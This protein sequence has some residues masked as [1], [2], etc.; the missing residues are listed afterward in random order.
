MIINAR[1]TGNLPYDALVIVCANPDCWVY[2]RVICRLRATSH[3]FDL[4]PQDVYRARIYLRLSKFFGDINAFHR[5]FYH[6]DVS[7]YGSIVW[8]LLSPTLPDNY[9]NPLVNLNVLCAPK[10]LGAMATFL[11]LSGYKLIKGNHPYRH[12]KKI[13]FTFHFFMRPSSCHR[14]IFEIIYIT[15]LAIPQMCQDVLMLRYLTP[16][17]TQ[18]LS[19]ASAVAR[20]CQL[21]SVL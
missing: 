19:R 2:P 12:N 17:N 13:L 21:A 7:I 20:P 16:T 5:F 8:T 10:D 18:N 3:E 1:I 15:D 6:F 14:T 9:Y 4:F 11:Q